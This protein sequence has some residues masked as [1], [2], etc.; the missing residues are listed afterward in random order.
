MHIKNKFDNFSNN[1]DDKYINLKL[2]SMPFVCRFLNALGENY[3][4]DYHISTLTIENSQY[5]GNVN[6][7][8]KGFVSKTRNKITKP[9]V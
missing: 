2:S 7:F 4:L 1:E 3:P 8:L 9:S 6:A 5:N